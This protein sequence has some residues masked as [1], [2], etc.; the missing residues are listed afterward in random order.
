MKIVLL[1]K[2][3][4]ALNWLHSQSASDQRML[5]ILALFCLIC[6]PVLLLSSVN[7][8]VGEAK[9]NY[10][11]SEELVAWVY[12][13]GALVSKKAG[14][15][16]VFFSGDLMALNSQLANR[17]SLRAKRADSLD[18][19]KLRLTYDAVAFD[20]LVELLQEF[21]AQGV[22]LSSVEISKDKATGTV[23]ANIILSSL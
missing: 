16:R 5:K 22:V 14:P 15:D 11:T 6:F 1:E 21:E 7:Q 2:Y 12:K 9:K 17:S 10:Q 4:T 13:N 8:W 18:A 3:Q 23:D 19:N 20:T